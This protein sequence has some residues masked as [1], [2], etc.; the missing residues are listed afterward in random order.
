MITNKELRKAL[1]HSYKIIKGEIP[2]NKDEFIKLE[3]FIFTEIE[4]KCYKGR[5]I[6][7]NKG[8]ILTVN[9]VNG[10]GVNCFQAGTDI[11]VWFQIDDLLK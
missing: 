6:K 10:Y 7:D 1:N 3:N 11:G 5:K 4:K 9:R 2:Y 8:K